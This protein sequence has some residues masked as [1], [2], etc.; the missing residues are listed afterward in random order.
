MTRLHLPHPHLAEP[1][2]HAFGEGIFA[3]FLHHQSPWHEPPV[4]TAPAAED[5]PE[6]HWPDGSN[7]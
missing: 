7:W 2:I 5:W 3:G 1:F 6:W 4:R